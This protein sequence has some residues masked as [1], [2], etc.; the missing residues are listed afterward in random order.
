M[1]KMIWIN[2]YHMVTVI[3][4][5]S[6]KMAVITRVRNLTFSEL[7]HGPAKNPP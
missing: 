6:G 3:T 2:A 1:K 5:N 4:V 7:R